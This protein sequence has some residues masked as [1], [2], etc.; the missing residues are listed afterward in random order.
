MRLGVLAKMLDGAYDCVVTCADAAAQY[1]LPPDVLL[2]RTLHLKAGTALPC[3]DL[4][5][6]LSAARL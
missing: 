1:T 5:A 3:A 6:A 4:A 2:R